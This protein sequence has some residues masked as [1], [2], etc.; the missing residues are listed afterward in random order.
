MLCYT[1]CCCQVHFG[2]RL[3]RPISWMWQP[4]QLSQVWGPHGNNLLFLPFTLLPS[5]E[6]AR[7]VSF[8]SM[9]SCSFIKLYPKRLQGPCDARL[10]NYMPSPKKLYSQKSKRKGK[11]HSF[12]KTF[13]IRHT[14]SLWQSPDEHDMM[15]SEIPVSV[16]KKIHAEQT[17]ILPVRHYTPEQG[18]WRAGDKTDISH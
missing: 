13:E 15:F 18:I 10:C 9:F 1:D 17:R 12:S 11:V 5:G 8:L 14:K 16:C 6:K 4:L 3:C 7:G 2:Q